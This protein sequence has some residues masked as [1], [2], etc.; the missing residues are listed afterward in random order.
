MIHGEALLPPVFRR[1]ISRRDTPLGSIGERPPRR[2]GTLPGNRGVWGSSSPPQRAS[3]SPT[4]SAARGSGAA[5]AAFL[6]G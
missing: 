5:G 3:S 2:R 6:E 4:A 1:G